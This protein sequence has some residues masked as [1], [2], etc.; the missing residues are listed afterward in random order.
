MRCLA[1]VIAALALLLAACGGDDDI[2]ADI[3]PT[4]EPTGQADETATKEPTKKPTA[5]P[6]PS[7][8][9]TPESGSSRENPVPFGQAVAWTNG[10]ELKVVSAVPDG[11]AQVMAQ[12][13]FNDPA[14][15]GSQFFLVTVSATYTGE[16]SKPF[17]ASF[18]LRAVGPTSV[19]YSTF[20]NSCGVIPDAFPSSEV[21]TG[22]TVQGNICWEVK[23]EDAVALVMYYDPFSLNDAERV[24][25]DVTP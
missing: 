5:K 10:W 16:G 1:L 3:Q 9:P 11:T 7:P 21:F 14:A 17:D 8:T 6:T 19:S 2:T 25:M 18:S 24:F 4:D 15:A 13:Q 23:T 20:E 22:G 12:N